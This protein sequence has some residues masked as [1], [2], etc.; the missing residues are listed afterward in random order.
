M[1]VVKIFKKNNNIISLELTGHTGYAENGKDIVC[2][3]VSSIVGS[4]LLG[5]NQVVKIKAEHKQNEKKGYF[6]LRINEN[7]SANQMEKAQILLQTAV[8]S[9]MELAESYRNFITVQF[10]GGSNEIY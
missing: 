3:S 4:C 9:L 6:S 5:L 1:T 7:I 2:S 8:L 10:T